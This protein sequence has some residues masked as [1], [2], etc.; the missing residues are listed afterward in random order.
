VYTALFAPPPFIV[1]NP[2][3]QG[4][5]MSRPDPSE[6]PEYYTPYVALAPEEE[7]LPALEHNLVELLGLFSSIGEARGDFRYAPGKWS[8]KQLA[9]HLTDCERVFGYRAL[10]MARGD[11]TILPGFDHDAYV[12]AAGF[13]RRPLSDLAVE[14]AHLRRANLVFFRSLSE[15]EWSRR[16]RTQAGEFSVRAFAY[17]LAGHERHHRKVLQER[18]I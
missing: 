13:E 4:G 8:I 12:A 16:G 1:E 6:Y 15:E 14:L 10:R 5:T 9:G 18:Y 7:I 2:A 17:I 3:R 11:A